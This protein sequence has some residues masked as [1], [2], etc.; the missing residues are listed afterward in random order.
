[1]SFLPAIPIG[2]VAGLR[3]LERTDDAQRAA[4][5]RSPEIQRNI[6]YFAE[7]IS[8]IET[9]DEL[10]ADRRLLTVAL[11]AF[12]LGD[13]IDKKAFVRK[14]LEDGVETPGTLG[15]RLNNQGYI[16]MAT[17]FRFD[18]DGFSRTGSP[19]LRDD[20]ISKYLS[21]SYEISVGEQDQS[22]RLALDFKRRA[23]EISDRGWYAMLGDR[24]TR[25]VLETA[26][27]I[28]SG[29]AGI[30]IDKQKELFEKRA[31]SVLGSSDP[32]ILSDAAVM[33]KV[34][35]RFLVLEQAKSGPNTTTPGFAALTLLNNAASGFGSFSAQSLFQ[36]SS[37]F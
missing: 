27:G 29:V 1:M 12:G 26:L 2:G 23:S 8:K 21:Q 6:A 25:A 33:D 28:P 10:V 32:T 34:V 17:A 7:N 30:D 20:V 24:P 22:L 16:D 15:S 19:N 35:A 18:R 36:S 4:H 14:I 3:F 11:G 37:R 5:A 9:A 31:L 13:E